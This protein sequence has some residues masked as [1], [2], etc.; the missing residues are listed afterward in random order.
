MKTTLSWKHFGV[1]S[2]YA[3]I[4]LF[5]T[6]WDSWLYDSINHY[7]VCWFFACG[8]AWMNGLIPYVDFSDSKGPL[9]WLIYGIGYLISPHNYL[10]VFLLSWIA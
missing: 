1:I 7:D 6:S 5:I 9:L 10:G 2:I 8:K 3:F 4:I